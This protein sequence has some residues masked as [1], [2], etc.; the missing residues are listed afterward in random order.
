MKLDLLEKTELF[1]TNIELA[2][3]N[4]GA[5]AA[6]VAQVLGLEANEVAVVD[7]REGILTLDILKPYV[8]LEQ[9]IGKE[10]EILRSLQA[11]PGVRI[12]AETLVHSEGVLGMVCLD[13]VE[14]PGLVERIQDMGNQVNL[15]VSRRIRVFPTGSEIITN[16][17]EDTNT[18]FIV[19]Q[20]NREGYRAVAGPV[21]ED[22][23]PMVVRAL[24]GAVEE[25]FGIVITTGGVGA[26]D[27]DHLVEA[28]Q[29]LDKEAAAPYLV[30]YHQGQGRHRKDG[31]RIAVGQADWTMFVA[32]PGPHD[33]V[34]LALP[35][36][37]RGLHEKWD[38]YRLAAA[39][40]EV[41]RQKWAGITPDRQGRHN[42]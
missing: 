14:T 33:E 32:L 7:V 8:Q 20:L 37:I 5:A 23:L 42:P 9:I 12:T 3:V 26:E 38:K 11:L 29:K 18:P 4:L 28:V 25:G 10:K 2:S 1:V 39:L 15:A 21:L 16:Y 40:A 34:R 35:V 27:K 22:D 41:L 31:V 13:P 24:Q 36:L 19:E 30:H 6:A 17:I